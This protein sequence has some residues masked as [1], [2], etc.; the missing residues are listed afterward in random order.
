MTVTG[1]QSLSGGSECSGNGCGAPHFIHSKAKQEGSEKSVGDRGR[2]RRKGQGSLRDRTTSATERVALLVPWWAR[3]RRLTSQLARCVR[4]TLG[5]V[6]SCSGGKL[7]PDSSDLPKARHPRCG[8]TR[9]S[10]IEVKVDLCQGS[11]RPGT[12]APTTS[13]F[14]EGVLCP[15]PRWVPS[16]LSFPRLLC[17]SP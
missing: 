3:D 4:T 8:K 14:S 16:G 9:G 7:C 17:R 10:C 6:V 11:C 15:A 2:G 13:L 1:K 12:R 5:P